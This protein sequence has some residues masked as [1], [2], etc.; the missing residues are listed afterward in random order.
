MKKALSNGATFGNFHRGK[1]GS[2]SAT[3][4]QSG[5]FLRRQKLIG[6]FNVKSP[7]S[8]NEKRI[9]FEIKSISAITR[10]PLDLPSPETSWR[11]NQSKRY[12]TVTLSGTFIVESGVVFVPQNSK[13]AYF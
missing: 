2:F 7:Q 1:W 12:R 3:K 10:D 8:V 9:D 5:L 11:L 6:D 4:F 13:A